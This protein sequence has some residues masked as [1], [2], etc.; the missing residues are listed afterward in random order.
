M[1]AN[2]QPEITKPTDTRQ[3]IFLFLLITAG[4]ILRIALARFFY[5]GT[6]DV[7][8][9]EQFST[10]WRQ[11]M[12]PYDA[13]H[14]W[15]YSPVWFW[16]LSAC[17]E[18]ARS[19]GLPFTFVIKWPLIL[20]DAVITSVL[21]LAAQKRGFSVKE[22]LFAAA[23]YALNPV[24][25][26]LSG[27]GAQFDNT[28]IAFTLLCWYW[29]THSKNKN[30]FVGLLLF[31]LGVLMKHFTLIL[32]PIFAFKEKGFLKRA[33]YFAVPPALFAALLL[34]Y[35]TNGQESIVHQVLGY[36][37]NAG[38]WG[39]SGIICRVFLFFTEIDLTRMSWFYWLDFFNLALYAGILLMTYWWVKK[40]DTLDL[41][42]LVF[43]VFYVFTTQIAP[44]YTVWILPFAAL[45][46]NL[47]FYFYS[48]IGGIQLGFFYYCHYFWEKH[49]LLQ[50]AD[51]YFS[52]TFIVA[53]HLTWLVCVLW[54]IWMIK[55][56]RGDLVR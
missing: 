35:F 7:S 3:V 10:Y 24:S 47:F 50:G 4:F 34:P 51:V 8:A 28:A 16:V 44:Q 56:K 49:I 15:S 32:A 36:N 25:I 38:Y 31:S 22:S 2:V 6:N 53:R 26:I 1:D 48:V 19:W 33:C 37:L 5:G 40:Y 9:W 17:S 14:R 39:W 30:Y 29:G 42:L 43:L 27:Y 45:R 52:K 20:T 12:S 54:L 21:F 41:I 11:G 46:R 13:T 18:F 23:I 55:R